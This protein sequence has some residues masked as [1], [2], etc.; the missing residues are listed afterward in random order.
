M[1]GRTTMKLTTKNLALTALFIALCTLVTMFIR[2]P[3][4]TSGYANLG[5]AM[6]LLAAWVLGPVYGALAAGLGSALADLIGYP[7]YA[8]ATFIIKFLV[9]FFAAKLLSRYTDIS[10]IHLCVIGCMC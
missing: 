6:V 9:A 5:D 8:P 4:P 7:I 10:F 2:I 1:K 3:L